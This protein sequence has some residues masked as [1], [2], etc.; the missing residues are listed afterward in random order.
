[1]PI[2]ENEGGPLRVDPEIVDHN[3]CRQPDLS[4][5]DLVS[6][7][8]FASPS[9]P[10]L[11]RALD[12]A[13]SATLLVLLAPLILFVWIT[14]RHRMGKPVLFRQNRIGKDEK[15]FELTKFRTMTDA[16]DPGGEHLEDSLRTPALGRFLRKTSLDELPELWSVLNGCMS[17]VGPR[18]LLPEYLPYYTPRESIRHTVRPGLTGLAQVEGRSHLKWD[19]QLELDARY[20]ERQC[21]LLDLKILGRTAL[22]LF[23]PKTAETPDGRQRRRLDEERASHSPILAAERPPRPNSDA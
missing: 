15:P 16:R 20:V 14:I 17:L 13:V 23:R 7:L 5:P 21:L 11:K 2:G 10:M 22:H 6:G 9:F 8:P 4:E 19:D 18:P 12:I 3:A 1:M